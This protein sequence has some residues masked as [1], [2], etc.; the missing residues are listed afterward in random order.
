M[1]NILLVLSFLVLVDLCFKPV[2]GV[3]YFWLDRHKGRKDALRRSLLTFF[4]LIESSWLHL[5]G[6]RG[7]GPFRHG[8]FLVCKLGPRCRPGPG[9]GG[10]LNEFEKCCFSL[11]VRFRLSFCVSIGVEFSSDRLFWFRPPSPFSSNWPVM[12]VNNSYLCYLFLSL[13]S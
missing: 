5:S 8:P 10:P 2:R 7:P 4:E 12:R 11:S 1:S 3:N 13:S 9:V 6:G